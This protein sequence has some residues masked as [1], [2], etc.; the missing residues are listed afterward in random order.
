[1]TPRE[2]YTAEEMS[3]KKI[4]KCVLGRH[5]V[6]LRGWVHMIF[7]LPRYVCLGKDSLSTN[8]Y[9]TFTYQSL[10]IFD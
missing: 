8:F 2:T 7:Y 6:Y 5:L 9:L 10:P 3:D 4:M 1:M